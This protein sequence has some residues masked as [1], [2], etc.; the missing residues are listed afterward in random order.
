LLP[1]LNG[2]ISVGVAVGDFNG[3]GKLDL[4]VPA[5]LYGTGNVIQVY[6]GNGGRHVPGGRESRLERLPEWSPPM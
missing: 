3:D 4:A 2:L 6:L 5:L 1:A